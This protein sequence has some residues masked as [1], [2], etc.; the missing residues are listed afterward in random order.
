MTAQRDPR[1]R[2]LKFKSVKALKKAIDAFF[3]DC[4]PHWIDDEVWDYPKGADGKP[5]YT[6][7]MVCTK[8]KRLT[9]QQPYTVTGLA[10]ALDTTRDTLLDYESGNRDLQPGDEGYDPKVPLFSDTVKKA[11]LKCQ[12]YTEQ[13][14]FRNTQVA[15]SIFSLKNNF[16][17]RDQQ[18]VDLSSGGK[19]IPLLGGLTKQ[20]DGNVPSDDSTA[21]TGEAS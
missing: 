5:D 20:G 19:P 7:E 14:L 1:G 13:A 2:P 17:W 16:G 18:A 8:M 12:A 21:E 11:K 10:L 3:A 15:G 6:K 4:D 9:Q